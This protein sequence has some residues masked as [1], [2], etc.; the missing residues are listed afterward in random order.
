MVRLLKA[1]CAVPGASQ[2]ARPDCREP[3][4]PGH[5]GIYRQTLRILPHA[6]PRPGQLQQEKRPHQRGEALQNASL[7]DP[8]EPMEGPTR[9]PLTSAS[10]SWGQGRRCQQEML[11]CHE[12]GYHGR[13]TDSMRGG[14]CHHRGSKCPH[15]DPPTQSK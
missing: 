5:A 9:Q 15:G 8:P 4:G 6:G 7:L 12:W 11:W 1:H 10:L 14:S 3:L 13:P 2:G